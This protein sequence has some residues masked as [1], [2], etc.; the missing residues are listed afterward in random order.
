MTQTRDDGQLYAV[1]KTADMTQIMQEG[2]AEI[3]QIQGELFTN[4]MVSTTFWAKKGMLSHDYQDVE[5]L[6]NVTVNQVAL[7][8]TPKMT[9]KTDYL[10]GN[11]KTN[12][13]ETNRPVQVTSPQAH[14]SS[15]ALKG[16]LNEGQYEF[17]N[18]RGSY[19][20][21]SR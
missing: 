8:K 14:F 18:I 15:Q 7:D 12:Q 3:N 13:I 10:R 16:N 19:A 4:G 21:A 1:V 20:P 6:Q 2:R 9:L 11:T 5:L 17:F